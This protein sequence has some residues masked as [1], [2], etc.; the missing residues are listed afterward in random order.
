MS[1]AYLPSDVFVTFGVRCLEL[2]CEPA[3]PFVAG[4]PPGIS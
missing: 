1:D 3:S 4:E 2:L